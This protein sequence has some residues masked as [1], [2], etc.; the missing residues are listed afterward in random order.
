MTFQVGTSFK[1]GWLE[2][3]VMGYGLGNEHH[4]QPYTRLQR[5][6]K[7][8]LTD[9]EVNSDQFYLFGPLYE[10]H[11]LNFDFTGSPKLPLE[12]KT[13]LDQLGKIGKGIMYELLHS[14]QCSY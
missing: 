7:R 1:P 12:I 11:C 4:L 8:Y 9:I 6:L 10:N 3:G 2:M 13:D 5:G 14:V